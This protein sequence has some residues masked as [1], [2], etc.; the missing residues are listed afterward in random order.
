MRKKLIAL[1]FV[2]LILLAGGLLPATAAINTHPIGKVENS[3]LLDAFNLPQALVFEREIGYAT[4]KWVNGKLQISFKMENLDPCADIDAFDL[5]IYA[6]NAYE[7]HIYADGCYEYL[8][9]TLD[10]TMKAGK[11]TFSGYCNLAAFP[12]AKYVYAAV[13]RYHFVKGSSPSPEY[14]QP[15]DKNTVEIAYDDLEWFY[16]T[17]E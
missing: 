7:E 3:S 4:W 9:F 15:N 5:A 6:E 2:C 11:I 8:T 13:E 10:R 17:I 16:W 12:N 14:A 1:L